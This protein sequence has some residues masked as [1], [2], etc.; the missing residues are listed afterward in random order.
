MEV[1]KA[2]DLRGRGKGLL[3]QGAG[4]E[5]NYFHGPETRT[6]SFYWNVVQ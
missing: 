4:D 3:D 2:N 5:T 1:V 6:S